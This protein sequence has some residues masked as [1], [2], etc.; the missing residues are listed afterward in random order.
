MHNIFLKKTLLLFSFHAQKLQR[1]R[2]ERVRS[3][4]PISNFRLCSH[5]SRGGRHRGSFLTPQ[6]QK[7]LRGLLVTRENGNRSEMLCVSSGNSSK[8]TWAW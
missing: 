2:F 6:S 3:G 1:N 7:L 8:R 5:V 4:K